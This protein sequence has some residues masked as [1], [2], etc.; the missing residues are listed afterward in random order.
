MHEG[1]LRK[2]GIIVLAIDAVLLSSA[3]VAILIR[4]PDVT[5]V[6]GRHFVRRRTGQCKPVDFVVPPYDVSA[7]KGRKV[8]FL[9]LW[10]AFSIVWI[11]NILS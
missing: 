5:T 3:S 6:T 11:S 4:D 9:G 7:A 8:G 2:A 10:S 1:W